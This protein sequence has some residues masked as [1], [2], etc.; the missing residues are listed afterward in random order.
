MSVC[1]CCKQCCR[2]WWSY[3]ADYGAFLITYLLFVL[4]VGEIRLRCRYSH[5]SLNGRQRDD[6]DDEP[7]MVSREKVVQSLNF[8]LHHTTKVGTKILLRGGCTSRSGSNVRIVRVAFMLVL[9]LF[10][11]LRFSKSCVQV[12]LLCPH[13]RIP[14]GDETNSLGL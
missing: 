3:L 6:L 1:L 10:L 7:Q 11:N 2:L 12:K 8:C 14:A 5:Q 13:S 4:F 9:E